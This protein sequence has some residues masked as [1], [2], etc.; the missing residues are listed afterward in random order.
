MRR[1]WC[2]Q[3]ERRSLKVAKRIV[4]ATTEPAT[5]T[6]ANESIR[7]NVEITNREIC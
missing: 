2:E 3:S 7:E 4:A 5:M 1:I 6:R